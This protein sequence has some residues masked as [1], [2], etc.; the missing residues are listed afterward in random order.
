[1]SRRNR[2]LTSTT[3][4]V[5]A[6]RAAGRSHRPGTGTHNRNHVIRYRLPLRDDPSVPAGAR[7]PQEWLSPNFGGH[8]RPVH[9]ES[10]TAVWPNDEPGKPLRLTEW[11][12]RP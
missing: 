4:A 8:R 12:W 6:T 3:E 5:D 1:M 9:R 11:L 10:R 2:R 7:P